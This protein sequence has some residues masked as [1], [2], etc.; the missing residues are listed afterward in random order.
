M[1]D[2]NQ[3]KFNWLDR[4]R[5]IAV[6]RGLA[7]EDRGTRL[8][9]KVRSWRGGSYKNIFLSHRMVELEQGLVPGID[10]AGEEI[11]EAWRA[12]IETV[13]GYERSDGADGYGRELGDPEDAMKE[14]GMILSEW[15][16]DLL[17]PIQRFAVALERLV[18]KTGKVRAG[19]GIAKIL[20]QQRKAKLVGKVREEMR[21]RRI[22]PPRSTAK[23]RMLNPRPAGGGNNEDP[24]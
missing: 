21:E 10:G 11:N 24:V 5:E 19:A 6:R 2:I 17:D 18:E 14:V 4:A 22:Y 16:S 1:A 9:F 23:K 3:E 12:L 15:E 7:F 13:I 8:A 20:E